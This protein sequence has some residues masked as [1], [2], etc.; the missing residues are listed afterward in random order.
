MIVKG[1]KMNIASH[2]AQKNVLGAHFRRPADE[3]CKV[4]FERRMSGA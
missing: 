2:I 1:L 4:L 3:K